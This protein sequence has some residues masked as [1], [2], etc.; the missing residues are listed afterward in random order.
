M[1]G[2][3]YCICFS[4][5]SRFVRSSTVRGIRSSTSSNTPSSIR[6]RLGSSFTRPAREVELH[7]LPK[8]KSSS[9]VSS[10]AVTRQW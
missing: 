6:T 5:T 7:T 1:P 8:M 10:S 2:S 4:D 9:T 3:S